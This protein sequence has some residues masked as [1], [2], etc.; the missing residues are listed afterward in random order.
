MHAYLAKRDSTPRI[1]QQRTTEPWH[2]LSI[3]TQRCV[4][5]NNGA[6]TPTCH[7]VDLSRCYLW[8]H[9]AGH[10]VFVYPAER[11][12]RIVYL[13]HYSPN[14]DTMTRSVVPGTLCFLL[15]IAENASKHIQCENDTR[16]NSMQ[17]SQNGFSERALW[18]ASSR[19]I[20]LEAFIIDR[21]IF[22]LA[23]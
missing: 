16:A 8:K 20:G 6:F 13:V 18:P 5:Q 19:A 3:Y 7:A 12:T 22:Y 21:A 2:G 1:Y 15:V 9:A 17:K 14:V 4:G 23:V 11:F 10:G